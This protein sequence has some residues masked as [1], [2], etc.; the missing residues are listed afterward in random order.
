MSPVKSSKASVLTIGLHQKTDGSIWTPLTRSDGWENP[1]WKIVGGRIL[2]EE[3]AETAALREYWEEV[4]LRLVNLRHVGGINKPS[5]NP[6]FTS[7]LQHIFVG[8]IP[9]LEGFLPS[10]IDGHEKL[11]NELFRVQ[12][13]QQAIRNNAE[14]NGYRIL[15]AH[16]EILE[17]QFGRIFG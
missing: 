14:L 4:G 8:E 7:H 9:S 2:P 15:N 13:I 5:N 12:D 3:E 6:R 16:S 11:Q 10:S 1:L 17:T